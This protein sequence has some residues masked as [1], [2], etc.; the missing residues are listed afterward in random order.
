MMGWQERLISAEKTGVT[1]LVEWFTRH[2]ISARSA[3]T[4]LIFELPSIPPSPLAS[5]SMVCVTSCWF[6]C[7]SIFLKRGLKC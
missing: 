7:S 3:A 1:C 2:R 6:L 5:F 4:C